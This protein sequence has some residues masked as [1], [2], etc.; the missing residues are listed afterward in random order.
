MLRIA[1]RT[2]QQ[3]GDVEIFYDTNVIRVLLQNVLVALKGLKL[4]I[5][6]IHMFDKHGCVI[7]F[8][9]TEEKKLNILLKIT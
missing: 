9:K 2:K 1:K 6:F 3:I 4:Q 5:D 7:C 8:C